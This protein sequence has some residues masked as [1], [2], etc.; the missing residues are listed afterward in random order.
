MIDTIILN[1]CRNDA[2]KTCT[3]FIN[4]ELVPGDICEFGVYTGRSLALLSYHN[5]MYFENENTINKANIPDRKCYGFDSWD[6]LPE[7]N[8]NHPRWVKGLFSKNH[9]YH[10]TIKNNA[11]V[12][13]KEVINF[14]KELGLPSPN[15]IQCEYTKL[16]L[17]TTI[18]QIALVHIDCDLYESTKNVL[19]LIKHKLVEGTIIMFDDWFNYKA[20]PNKGEQKAFNEFL[21]DNTNIKV[22]EFL[23]Y[24]T[25]CKAFVVIDTKA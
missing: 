21:K 15:L 25:F 4:Y 14:F 13:T 7:D 18:H 1:E 2:F 16:H 8:D 19:N 12:T 20:N 22:V 11:V 6:G 5:S 24:A 23:R 17:P 3:R 9:S 10:P